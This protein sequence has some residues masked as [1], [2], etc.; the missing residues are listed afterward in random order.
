MTLSM[1]QAS[2]RLVARLDRAPR[3]LLEA[4]VVLEAWGGL[5][6][7]SALRAATV[8][9]DGATE[10]SGRVRRGTEPERHRHELV[11]QLMG[12]VVVV[13][14]LHYATVAIGLAAVKDGWLAALPAVIC[15]QWT[16]RRR[17]VGGRDGAGRTRPDRF[18][19]AIALVLVGTAAVV[20]VRFSPAAALGVAVVEIQL[21]GLF[22]S[23]RRWTF[24]YGL[25]VAAVIAA[26]TRDNTL[27]VIAVA[28]LAVGVFASIAILTT[29]ASPYAPRPW[30]GTIRGAL[31]G[32]ALGT[33]MITTF[34]R[35]TDGGTAIPILSFVPTLAGSAWAGLYLAR[36]WVRVPSA[37]TS[38][39]LL[40]GRV[41]KKPASRLARRA[42]TGV[43]M[44]ALLRL[45]VPPVLMSA[46][47]AFVDRNPGVT[48][49]LADLQVELVVISLIGLLVSLFD[50]FDRQNFALAVL[51][52]SLGV[53][54]ALIATN[55]FPNVVVP[56][57]VGAGSAVLIAIVPLC[58]L[59]RDPAR[60]FAQYL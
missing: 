49:S 20:L 40:S 52:V 53:T 25:C 59:L 4:A 9:S 60:S 34:A 21:A 1:E 8:S 2:A 33:L 31:C 44:G 7:E 17:Y 5:A 32:F 45:L 22:L 19:I 16:L 11:A 13:A 38:T 51:I 6:P 56:L 24:W 54:V 57:S 50:T 43:V 41:T 26:E 36:L 30:V 29:P 37:L 39:D 15:V 46:V 47:Y 14:W 23:W 35:N 18:G 12:L 58:Q 28:S 10:E 48:R 27:Y 42:A 55:R 3:D